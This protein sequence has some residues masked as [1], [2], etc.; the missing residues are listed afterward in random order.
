MIRLRHQ[1]TTVGVQC[2]ECERVTSDKPDA[3]WHYGGIAGY[4]SPEQVRKEKLDARTDLFSLVGAVRDG[5][6]PARVRGETVA[7][8]TMQFYSRRPLPHARKSNVLMQSSA[9][10]WKRTV[11]GA[12][13]Q[14]PRCARI[15][16]AP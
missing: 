6:W 13:N 4:M 15:W 9:R 10:P 3:T 1:R 14:P 2:A 5:G 12:T 16:R 11:S 8:F 7:G